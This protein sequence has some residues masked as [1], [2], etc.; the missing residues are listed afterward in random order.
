MTFSIP[1]GNEAIG[2]VT[3]L[4]ITTESGTTIVSFPVGWI[5][6]KLKPVLFGKPFAK[7]VCTFCMARNNN[8]LVISH[9]PF[10]NWKAF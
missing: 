1:K 6:Y 8:D 9:K 4:L 7:Q 2:N 10:N 3:H 5:D